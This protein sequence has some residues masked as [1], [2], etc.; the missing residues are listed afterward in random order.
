M[1]SPLGYEVMAKMIPLSFLTKPSF[2]SK[3]FQAGAALGKSNERSSWRIDR[4][5]APRFQ[6]LGM[7]WNWFD[8]VRSSGPSAREERGWGLG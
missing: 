1:T 3:K 8:P 2:I 7:V 4:R 5:E 6:T